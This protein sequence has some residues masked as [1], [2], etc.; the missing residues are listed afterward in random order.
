MQAH[1]CD[2]HHPAQ[3][4]LIIAYDDQRGPR[5]GSR[6]DRVLS[7]CRRPLLEHGRYC[8]IRLGGRV[9]CAAGA[10]H[11]AAILDRSSC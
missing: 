3:H 4:Q 1:R 11:L 6:A 10:G 9:G 5:P 8:T 7:V 2:P